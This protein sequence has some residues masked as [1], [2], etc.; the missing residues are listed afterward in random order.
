MTAGWI[1]LLLGGCG[2][3]EPSADPRWNVPAA[4]CPTA[5][6]A[7][8]AFEHGAVRFFVAQGERRFDAELARTPAAEARGLMYR[9]D[10]P[11]DAAMVFSTATPEDARF[12]MH[13]TCLPLDL[14]WVAADGTVIE[15]QTAAAM[16]EAPR[17]AMRRSVHVVELGAGVASANGIGPGTRVEVTP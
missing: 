7:G 14:V 15:V 11:L 5:P 10:L 4:G 1:L 16:E 9:R 12:W 2:R 17:G 3:I 8:P 13:D 6:D